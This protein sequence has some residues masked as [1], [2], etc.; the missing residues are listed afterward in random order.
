MHEVERLCRSFLW[1]GSSNCNKGGL[2]FGS[3]V[4]KSKLN[5]G[6]GVKPLQVWS[7]ATITKHIWDIV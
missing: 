1:Y 3:V 4:C 6:L 5:G 7:K 2:I